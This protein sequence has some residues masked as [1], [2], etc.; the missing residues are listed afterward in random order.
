MLR[1]LLQRHTVILNRQLTERESGWSEGVC[2][3]DADRK[4]EDGQRVCV[5]VCVRDGLGEC[6][7][8][9][10]HAQDTHT[11]TLLCLC[12]NTLDHSVIMISLSSNTIDIVGQ[13]TVPLMLSNKMVGTMSSGPLK[14]VSS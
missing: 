13:R 8:L 14:A 6:V 7:I 2:F 9:C 5:C 11:C 10:V 12:V 4:R 1:E 3:R